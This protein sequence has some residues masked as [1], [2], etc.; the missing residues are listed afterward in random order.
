[1][2]S[3]SNKPPPPP[4]QQQQRQQQ[5]QQHHTQAHRGGGGGG[6][7]GGVKKEKNHKKRKERKKDNQLDPSHWLEVHENNTRCVIKE[8]QEPDDDV[9]DEVNWIRADRQ[10]FGSYRRCDL[11]TE[12]EM[13]GNE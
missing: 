5:Q 2:K 8:Y 4:P 7:G 13:N 12:K 11:T 3:S 10:D 1:M 9:L 6:G